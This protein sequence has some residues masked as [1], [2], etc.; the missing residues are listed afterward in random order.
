MVG[1]DAAVGDREREVIDYLDGLG[2]R[3]VDVLTGLIGIPSINPN[4]PGCVYDELVGNETEANRFLAGYYREAGLDVEWV[5]REEGRAN[6]VGVLRGTGASGGRSLA[7]N[8][9]VDVVPPAELSDWTTT[10]DPFRAT[11][12]DGVIY[13]RGASDMKGGLVAALLAAEAIERSGVRLRGDLL[14]HS[15]VG[16]ETGDHQAGVEAVIEAGY[17]G[18]GAIVAESTNHAVSPVSAGLLWLSLSVRGKAGH[19]NLRAELVRAGG[20]G[21]DA[22]VNALEKGVF[23]V[24]MIQELEREWGRSKAHPMFRP[25]W[26]SL[27]PGVMVAA[28]EGIRVPFMISTRCDLEYSITY[29]PNESGTEIRREIE[30]FVERASR[31]D[32]WLRKNPPACE[33]RLDWPPFVT[34]PAHE[35]VRTTAAA[36]RRV[37]GVAEGKDRD[38]VTGY[39]AVCDATSFARAGI[40]TVVYGGGPRQGGHKADE[41]TEVDRII[42]AAKTYALAAMDWCGV[43][44]EGS[45]QRAMDR[46]ES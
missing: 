2:D 38:R 30:E 23:L 19:N 45:G 33:W 42:T 22:G 20:R 40:P 7:V 16:E 37:A 35:I 34:D 32:P 3:A 25:G 44:A 31:L 11:V 24:T 6:L 1:H 13:G 12:R 4:Y 41:F 29:P 36:Y 27:H 39:G 14:L 28:P 10:P 21:E 43:D 46:E 26:F 15:V 18:D 8:G 17:G 9:H 5:E